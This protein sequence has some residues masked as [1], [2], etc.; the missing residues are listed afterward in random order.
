MFYKIIL[1]WFDCTTETDHLSSHS[2][3][4]S[5]WEAFKKAKS[6]LKQK[7]TGTL[8]PTCAR[9]EDRE[10]NVIAVFDWVEGRPERRET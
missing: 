8:I 7:D 2:I 4:G 1:E 6:L 5:D 3:L 9:V 10:E